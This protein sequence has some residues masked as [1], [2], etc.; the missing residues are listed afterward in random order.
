MGLLVQP[1]AETYSVRST[2]TSSRAN[3]SARILSL[4]RRKAD[5]VPT[6]S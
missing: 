5:V 4:L 1:P 3:Q 6:S 2:G